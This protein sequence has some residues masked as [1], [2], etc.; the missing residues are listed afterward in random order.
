MRHNVCLECGAKLIKDEIALSQKMLGRQIT[1]FYCVKC[2]ATELE[3]EQ[4][5]LAIKILEFKEQ[6]CALFL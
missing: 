5:D 4:E 2:L 6:G 1:S 3:C